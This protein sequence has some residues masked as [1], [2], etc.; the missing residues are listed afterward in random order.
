[1]LNLDKG[2]FR[3]KFIHFDVV[4]EAIFTGKAPLT[5]V[6]FTSSYECECN[7]S[8]KNSIMSC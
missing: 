1:M 6:I 5:K 2:V 4:I 3:L 8:S 7:N